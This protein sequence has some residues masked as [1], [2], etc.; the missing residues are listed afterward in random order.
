MEPLELVFL[1]KL[2]EAR[3]SRRDI[4]IQVITLDSIHKINALIYHV[5]L[6]DVTKEV[7][8]VLRRHQSHHLL[9][10]FKGKIPVVVPE[11]S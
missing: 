7:D 6:A 2:S 10:L 11:I 9:K 4:F 1:Y 8:L 3:I 5:N